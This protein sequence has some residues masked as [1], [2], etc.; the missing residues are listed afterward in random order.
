MEPQMRCAGIAD[1][2]V[3]VSV[4]APSAPLPIAGNPVDCRRIGVQ[5]AGRGPGFVAVRSVPVRSHKPERYRV[6]LPAPLPILGDGTAWVVACLASRI[7][8]R[9]R[10]PDPPPTLPG[11]LTWS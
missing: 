5:L 7:L 10:F 9:V 2:G 6:R 1:S 11:S 4:L 3:P 8:S